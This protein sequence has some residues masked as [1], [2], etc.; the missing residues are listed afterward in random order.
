MSSQTCGAGDHDHV[1]AC[2][3]FIHVRGFMK[4]LALGKLTGCEEDFAWLV[5]P[6]RGKFFFLRISVQLV[7]PTCE[8]QLSSCWKCQWSPWFVCMWLNVKHSPVISHSV[9][10]TVVSWLVSLSPDRAVQVWTLAKD[11]PLCSWA[12]HVTLTVPLS[13]QMHKWVLA[14]VMLEVT[15]RWTGIPSRWE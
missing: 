7:L 1:S 9:G 5:W 12:R 15:L 2:T 13:T 8:N 10:G 4:G 6:S 3:V 11:I 14:N